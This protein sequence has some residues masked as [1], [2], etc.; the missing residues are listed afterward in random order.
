MKDFGFLIGGAG[1]WQEVKRVG[2]YTLSTPGGG[3]MLPTIVRAGKNTAQ[4]YQLTL[5]PVVDPGHDALLIAYD[6]AARG[7]RLYRSGPAPGHLPDHPGVAVGDARGRQPGVGRPGGPGHVRQRQH[8]LPVLL[9][10]PGFTRAGV[11]YV[12]DTDGWTDFS[13]NQSMTLT[14]S[15]AG[16]G[17]V[18]LTGELAAG[19]GLLAAGV[20]GQPGRGPGRGAGEPGRRVRRDGGGIH[21]GLARPGRRPSLLPAPARAGPGWPTRCGSRRWCCAPAPTTP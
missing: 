4:A 10:Q 18:A 21:P 6:L 9:A 8:L 14:Y 3:L 11:G 15:Q 19:S 12:G 20:R 16:P 7:G 13:R 5:R 1:W 17:V 2:N